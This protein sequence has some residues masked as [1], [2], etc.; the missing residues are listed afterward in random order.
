MTPTPLSAIS[1][2]VSSAKSDAIFYAGYFFLRRHRWSRSCTAPVLRRRL[3]RRTALRPTVRQAGRSFPK[4]A[5]LSCPCGPA[6]ASYATAYKATNNAE[7]GVYSTEGYDLTTIMLG[8]AGVGRELY[9]H[10]NTLRIGWSRSS[11][12]LATSDTVPPGGS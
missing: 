4:G 5:V 1:T 12:S 2:Q 10:Y 6:P 8:S 11:G 3:W 7:H 9:V